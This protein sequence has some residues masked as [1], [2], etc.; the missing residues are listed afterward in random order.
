MRKCKFEYLIDDY[1]LNKLSENEKKKFEEH[2]F[3]CH[4]CF[5]K[6]VEKDEII[7]VVKNKGNVIFQDIYAPEKVKRVPLFERFVDFVTPKQ[8][9]MAAASA[10]LVLIFVFGILPSLKTISPHFSIN[11]DLVRGGSVT[12]I[13]PVINIK[14]V[15]PQF[16]WKSE[17]KDLEY[18]IYIYNHTLLWSTSTK[19]NYIFLPEDIKKLMVAGK[20]YSWQVKAFSP[21]GTL[22]A[23]SSRV[24]FMIDPNQ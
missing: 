19:N 17:G 14:T 20:R 5:K 4:Q 23:V 10:A 7:S 18:K 15:P 8:W 12:L 6:M 22:I 11:E 2:Y 1:L 21:E 3:D 9:A 13:S 24:Q 16:R